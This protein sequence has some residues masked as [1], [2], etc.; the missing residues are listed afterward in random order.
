MIP[1]DKLLGFFRSEF[2]AEKRSGFARLK[3]V[4]DS[5]VKESLGYYQSLS[6]RDKASWIDCCAHYALANYSFVIP[7]MRPQIK[8][9]LARGTRDALASAWAEIY[10]DRFD[11]TKHPFFAQWSDPNARFPFRSMCNVPLLRAAVSQYKIDRHRGV[12][13]CVSEDL[14]RFAESVP[15]LK[16][17]ELRKR[18]RA[19]LTRFGYRQTDAYGGHRCVWE[20]QEFE[21][22]VD[23]GARDAQLR[24]SVTP[25]EFRPLH[26]LGRFCLEVA[27]G[28]GLGHWNYIVE[29]NV[30]DGFLLL[31]ELIRYAVDLPRRI[32]AAA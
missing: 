14:F 12:P 2:L 24:Y 28:M 19:V 21:V 5:R 1:S 9:L 11:H 23:F 30:D 6:A 13:S 25:T 29:E 22:N 31:E 20:G 16:A 26:P 32:R 7:T 4:P 17:P 3:R 27:L 8:E 10:K 18:V 15:S